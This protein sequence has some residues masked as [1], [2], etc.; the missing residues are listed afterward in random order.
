MDYTQNFCK[1][2]TKENNPV[3]E[4]MIDMGGGNQQQKT[5]HIR[6]HSGR[7]EIYEK[8]SNLSDQITANL[9]NNE[10]SLYI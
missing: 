9:S 10:I 2:K 6:K 4:C 1:L 5:I 7:P 3:E 8:I